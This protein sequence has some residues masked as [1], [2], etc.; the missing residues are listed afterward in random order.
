[1]LKKTLIL[2]CAMAGKMGK[3]DATLKRQILA[4]LTAVR[5]KCHFWN[6]EIKPHKTDMV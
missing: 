2:G 4:F 5:Q 3:A 6:P 1:M